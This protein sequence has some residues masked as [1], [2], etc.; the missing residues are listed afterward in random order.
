[1]LAEPEVGRPGGGLLA[2]LVRLFVS[3]GALFAHL[4]RCN[5]SGGALLVLVLANLL[6][7]ALLLSTGWPDYEIAAQAQKDISRTDEQLKGDENSE[8][9]TRAV[10]AL[11]KKA[12]FD[13]L[14][15]RVLLIVGKP[16]WLLL[17]IATVA[18]ALFLAVAL[19]GAAKADFR[20]LWGIVVFAS[21]VELL[22]LPL[23]LFLV[24]RLRAVRVE[25]SLAALL[26]GPARGPAGFLQMLL[27]RRFD[28][29][30]V[31]FWA[32]VGLGLWKTGQMTGRR[33]VVVTVLLAL[34]TTALLMCLDVSALAEYRAPTPEN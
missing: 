10:E 18:S 7:A 4:P 33:A 21:C 16:L 3:P 1:V 24:M 25:T 6:Y 26:T 28:P 11:E 13:K 15:R 17:G 5:R 31:W 27:L 22:R 20:Q 12:E 19:G 34:A 8:E 32:L 30:E 9:R 29:F 23:V 14:F 2:D